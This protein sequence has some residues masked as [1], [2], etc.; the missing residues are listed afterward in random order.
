MILPKF[1]KKWK[2]K[3]KTYSIAHVLN[4][5]F[6]IYFNFVNHMFCNLET[7]PSLITICTNQTIRQAGNLL[8]SYS[9]TLYNNTY[10]FWLIS[11]EVHVYKILFKT[12]SIVLFFSMLTLWK[13]VLCT[14]AN[15]LS[16]YSI[17]FYNKTC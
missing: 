2:K 6:L 4:A 14:I 7:L 8:S 16:C 11:N 10:L 1:T 13:C 5:L 9:I 3:K 15:L 17:T 12:S